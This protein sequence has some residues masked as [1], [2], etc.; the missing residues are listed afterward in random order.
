MN[1]T[2]PE[3]SDHQETNQSSNSISGPPA[4][5][6]TVT[7]GP[8]AL[9]RTMTNGP[10]T[11]KRTVTSGPPALKRTMTNGPPALKRTVTSGLSS[12][13]ELP[14]SITGPPALKRTMTSGQSLTDS[15]IFNQKSSLE[16]HFPEATVIDGINKS[17]ADI[18]KELVQNKSKITILNLPPKKSANEFE[19]KEFNRFYLTPKWQ[20]KATDMNIPYPD[21]WF[22]ITQIKKDASGNPESYNINGSMGGGIGNISWNEPDVIETILRN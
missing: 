11:L 18:M 15:N 8:P 12:I 22:M 9:K 1:S 3:S 2:K 10:P 4:L 6:R 20:Q 16:D 7:S 13:S 19:L 21:E 14:V 5:K 17:S